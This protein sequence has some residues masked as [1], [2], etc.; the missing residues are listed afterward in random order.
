MT[1]PGPLGRNTTCAFRTLGLG[2]L[3]TDTLRKQIA[4]GIA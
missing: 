2:S 3:E 4:P 1:E